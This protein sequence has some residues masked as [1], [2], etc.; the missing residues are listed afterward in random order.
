[1]NDYYAKLVGVDHVGIAT[2]DMFDVSLVVAFAKKNASMYADGG[3]MIDAFERGATGNGE[4]AKILA[5]ITDDLWERGYTNEDLAK[6]YGGNKMRVY[7][8]VWEGVSPQ[9]HQAD[10]EDRVNL[11][12]ALK[13]RFELR[14]VLGRSVLVDP[15]SASG[16]MLI[17]QHVHHAHGG[18]AGAEEV[19]ALRH[20]GA[21]Q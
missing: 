21:D 16:E 20:A 15:E 8:Q 17:A 4:L 5:A 10:M 7:Q 6:I 3:Y 1:M 11:R 13:Q 18:D 12:K 14:L 9:R 19:G 2:D